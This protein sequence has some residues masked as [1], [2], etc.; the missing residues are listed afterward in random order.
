MFVYLTPVQVSSILPGGAHKGELTT[1]GHLQV[2][3]TAVRAT[4]AAASHLQC[5]FYALLL[6]IAALQTAT[7][8]HAAD[9]SAAERSQQQAR[10]QL[11]KQPATLLHLRVARRSNWEGLT[12]ALLSCVWLQAL[13]LGY[14]LRQQY[15]DLHGFLPP[16]YKSGQHSHRIATGIVAAASV[17]SQCLCGCNEFLMAGWCMFA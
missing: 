4:A 13:E 11:Q 12:C 7:L 6:H 16:V 2:R 1:V 8:S 14:W 10:H 5:T 3:T 15:I 9:C 17:C